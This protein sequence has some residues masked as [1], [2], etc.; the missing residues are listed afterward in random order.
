MFK[1]VTKSYNQKH[2]RAAAEAY[3][4]LYQIQIKIEVSNKDRVFLKTLNV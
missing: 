1:N 2:L 4:E 3:L